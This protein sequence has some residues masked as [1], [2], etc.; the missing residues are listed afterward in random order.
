MAVAI[1]LSLRGLTKAA[2]EV[3]LCRA[4]EVKPKVAPAKEA[5]EFTP[6]V[7]QAV[8]RA[9]VL[10]C[11]GLL[12]AHLAMYPSI[13]RK[14]K[15]LE[16]VKSLRPKIGLPISSLPYSK[17]EQTRDDLKN[18]LSALNLIIDK[19]ISWTAKLNELPKLIPPGVWLTNLSF[20]QKILKDNKVIR[21]VTLRGIAYYENP[22]RGIEVITALVSGLNE[23][24]EFSRGFKEIKLDS[25]TSAQLEGMTVKDFTISCSFKE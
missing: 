7:R 21:S 18:K 25:M 10:S 22:G 11:I 2:A 1:G 24:K 15:H 6:E 20:N 5:F 4:E 17:L 14:N 12:A 16:L 9:V 8:F 23:N 3:N 19:R 13:A